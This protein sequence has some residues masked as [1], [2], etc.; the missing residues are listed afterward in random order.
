MCDD[1]SSVDKLDTAVDSFTETLSSAFVQSCPIRTQKPRSNIWWNSE[2]SRLRAETRRLLRI[3][4]ARRHMPHGPACFGVL[5]HSRNKYT[6]EIRNARKNSMK[7]YFSKIEG[8]KMT[9][10]IHRILATDP[11]QGPGIR[12]ALTAV[13]QKRLRKQRNS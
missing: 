8:A 13:S 2:L 6:K 4:L 11:T 9:S 5:R 3:Y 10:R 7:N 1:L 12:N